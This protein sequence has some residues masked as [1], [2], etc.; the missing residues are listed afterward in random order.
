MQS[1]F[2]E[3]TSSFREM[4]SAFQR[5]TYSFP[6]KL[7]DKKQRL[8]YLLTHKISQSCIIKKK[9]GNHQNH[10]NHGSDKPTIF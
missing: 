9:H 10:K 7:T 1:S 4:Q 3:I 8:I 5:M 6:E 2:Q